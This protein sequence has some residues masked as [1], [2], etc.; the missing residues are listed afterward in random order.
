MRKALYILADLEDRDLLWLSGA[1]Q[2]RTLG[3]GERLIEAGREVRELYFVTDGRL[4][5]TTPTGEEIAV[6][7]MGEV[8]GEMSFVEKRPP[9]ASVTALETAR[10]L[11][12]PR[13]A[14][15]AEFERDKAF[16]ARFYR[17]LAVFLSDRL[18]SA[19]AHNPSGVGELDEAILD[20]VHQAG[21]RF[22][23]LVNLL[24]GRIR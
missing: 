10:V 22:V 23:R 11:A 13:D 8:V 6:L 19:T 2:V 24:E 7:T 15:L 18:R 21:E 17:A 9:G 3:A 20:G 12:I 5:V 16:A 14:I 1:G 4:A